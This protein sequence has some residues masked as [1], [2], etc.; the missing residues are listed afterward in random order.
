MSSGSAAAYAGRDR[1]RPSRPRRGAGCCQ[2]GG[3]MLGRV[4]VHLL[5]FLEVSLGNYEAAL[6]ALEPLIPS[7]DAGR[8][9]R[10][11]RRRIRSRR[12]RG[13]DRLGRLDEA[14]PLVETARTQRSPAGPAWML[15]VGGRCRAMLL[16][17][18]GDIDAAGEAAQRRWRNT[19]DCRCRSNGR[20]PSCC[21]ANC[22]AADA[23]R[24]PPR[25]PCAKPGDLRSD[26]HP[27]VGRPRPRRTGRANVGAH[28]ARSPHP[29]SGSPNWRPPA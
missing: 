17:A 13:D 15:A 18:R 2:R 5:G 11:S 19:T 25:P 9:R 21:W 7:F 8:Q 12:R 28:I 14:E 22:S 6:T 26:G 3:A 24:T 16:A 29:S 4:A 10:R 23:R 1:R 20:A 27:A